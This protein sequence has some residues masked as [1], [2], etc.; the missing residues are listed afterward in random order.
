MKKFAI[1]TDSCSDLNKDLREKYDIDYVPMHYSYDG[2]DVVANLDWEELSAPDFYN[3]MR[4]GTR[5][6]T[7]Q[8]TANDYKEKFESYLEKGY[9]I[10]SISCSSALSA[11]V[12]S[13]Y[14][15]RDELCAK[16]PDAKIIC[17]DSL[18]ACAGEGMLVIEASKKRAE[19]KS[20]EEVASFI[21]NAKKYIHQ[22]AIADKLVYLKQAGRVSAASAFFGGLLNVKPVIISDAKGQNFAV[23]K[24]KGRKNSIIR[25]AE[26]VKEQ[27][28]GE[29]AQEIFV[30]HADCE[31]EAIEL[32]NEIIARIPRVEDKITIGYIGPIVGA[33]VGPGMMGVYFFGTEVTENANE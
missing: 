4:G 9:D 3:V 22:E 24:V 30:A 31:S 33:S 19:G 15:V 14:I 32:K 28:N 6:F 17:I 20:I 16:Y 12:K 11:S 10:L 26:R 27:Y 21:E 23:E 1:I 29:I 5:I 7:A 2:K 18:I 8:V 13:S 25:I